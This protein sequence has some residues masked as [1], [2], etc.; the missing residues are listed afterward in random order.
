ME[1]FG[2]FLAHRAGFAGAVVSGPAVF[3]ASV[4]EGLAE[5]GM[6]DF[7]DLDSATARVIRPRRVAAETRLRIVFMS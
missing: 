4:A 5:D 3:T 6:A 1:G 7:A 2:A